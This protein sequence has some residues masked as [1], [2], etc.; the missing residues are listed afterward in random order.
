MLMLARLNWARAYSVLAWAFAASIVMSLTACS[1]QSVVGRSISFGQGGGSEPYRTSGWSQAEQKF[2]WS[3]G[4]SAKLSLPIGK[5]S[6]PLNLNVAMAAYT[7]PPEL[8]SQPVEVY[9][10]GQ[11]LAEWEVNSNTAGYYVTIPADTVKGASK[12]EI[13]FR[14]PKAISP[15]SVGAGQDYRVLGVCLASL[16]L[17]KP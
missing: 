13:E 1:E 17:A 8:R 15:K 9:V 5:E 2:T 11:K 7:H 3:E 14:T 12:L 10:N 16:E 4:N 6:G